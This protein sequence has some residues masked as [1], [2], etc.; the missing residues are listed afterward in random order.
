MG[1]FFFRETTLIDSIF[2]PEYN[3]HIEYGR[4]TSKKWWIGKEY[5]SFF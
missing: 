2:R 3:R 5:R 4:E 1:L